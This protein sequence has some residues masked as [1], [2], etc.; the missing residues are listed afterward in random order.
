MCGILDRY[1]NYY[2]ACNRA[3]HAMTRGGE[4]DVGSWQPAG[5]FVESVSS[6]RA[7]K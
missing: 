4:T 5:V 1:C 6:P 3:P 7:R 2:R